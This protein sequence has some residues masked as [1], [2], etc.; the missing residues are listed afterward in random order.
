M[1]RCE[2]CSSHLGHLVSC[3]FF[4]MLAPRPTTQARSQAAQR[5][6]ADV[7]NDVAELLEQV[8]QLEHGRRQLIDEINRLRACNDELL[9]ALQEIKALCL[10]ERA[11]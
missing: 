3:S 11:Q 6:R 10:K 1:S 7:L 2:E 4:G 9:S 5:E 8:E